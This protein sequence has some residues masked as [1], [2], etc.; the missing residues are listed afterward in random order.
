M[1]QRSQIPALVPR[2]AA[3][4][5]PAWPQE[6][7]CATE[8][9]GQR[10]RCQLS[11]ALQLVLVALAWPLCELRSRGGR[12]P[13]SMPKLRAVTS[14][15]MP[16]W[17]LS[18]RC[19]L[20][21]L[22]KL[23]RSPVGLGPVLHQCVEEGLALFRSL[24]AEAPCPSIQTVR[25]DIMHQCS[26]TLRVS[27]PNYKTLQNSTFVCD[28]CSRL[29]RP[30]AH[31]KDRPPSHSLSPFRQHTHRQRE[32]EIEI[33]ER[34]RGRE[35]ERE[36]EK[37]ERENKPSRQKCKQRHRLENCLSYHGHCHSNL[38][39]RPRSVPWPS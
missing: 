27:P 33:E 18:T 1:F 15:N 35:R 13:Q 12:P 28:L 37:R 4:S 7:V 19:T 38:K 25:D 16:P 39:A 9:T 34:E 6:R 22:G 24:D 21:A 8:T 10:A 17:R 2:G 26:W 29:H 23:P 31:K 3:V 36:R 32:K 20:S 5:L 14:Y 30:L 11:L